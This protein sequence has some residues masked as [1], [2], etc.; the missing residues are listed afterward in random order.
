MLISV[1]S[2]RQGGCDLWVVL[3]RLG[4][5]STSCS[6]AVQWGL[7]SSE[8]W[9]SLK[10]LCP[11]IHHTLS[12][13]HQ[14][15]ETSDPFCRQ[16]TLLSVN[17]ICGWKK[18]KNAKTKPEYSFWH[19]KVKCSKANDCFFFNVDYTFRD[20]LQWAAEYSEAG[21]TFGWPIIHKLVT[22]SV[23]TLSTTHLK[24]HD[25]PEKQLNRSRFSLTVYWFTGAETVQPNWAGDGKKSWTLP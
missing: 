17:L 22:Q 10:G 20:K 1:K 18:K 16:L 25:T 9:S 6:L 11:R 12:T 23:S 4:L 15:R 8:S 24:Q 14:Q 19:W 5:H 2:M 21:Q 7:Y 13:L 3:L